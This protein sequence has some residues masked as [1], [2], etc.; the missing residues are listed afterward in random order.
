MTATATLP[1]ENMG[2]I[3]ALLDLPRGSVLNLD[4]ETVVLRR[5]DFIGFHSIPTHSDTIQGKAI[6]HA[7]FA[8]AG[9]AAISGST[10]SGRPAASATTVGFVFL[11]EEDAALANSSPSTF[12]RRFDPLTEEIGPAQVEE[13]VAANLCY[14]IAAGRLEQQ[15]AVSYQQFTSKTK[16]DTWNNLTKF[17]SQRLLRRRGIENGDKLVPGSYS[18]DDE[19]DPKAA[20]SIHKATTTAAIIDGTSIIYPPIPVLNQSLLTRHTKHAGTK[21]FL[22]EL[23]P[24][25]RTAFFIDTSPASLVLKHLLTIEYGNQFECLL[26]DLQLSYVLFLNLHCYTSFIHWRDLVAMLSAVDDEGMVDQ[27]ELYEF[28]FSVMVAQVASMEEEFFDD[29]VFSGDN[30]LV[31]ALRQLTATA[32]K[33]VA[34]S[35][36]IHSTFTVALSRLGNV[37]HD[38][39]PSHFA[40]DRDSGLLTDVPTKMV[41]D[42][43]CDDEESL[44]QEDGPV[45]VVSTEEVEASIARSVEMVRRQE[46]R[47]VDHAMDTSQFRDRYPMLVAA[48]DPNTEDLLMTCARALD[49]AVDVSLV[50]EAAAYLEEVEAMRT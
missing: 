23:A 37:L 21:L 24:T 36:K 27:I 6:F 42:E 41:M 35:I 40:G 25:T 28:L 22:K 3:L 38:K 18:N 8:R 14:E 31:P 15:R 49:E 46:K 47:N 19:A 2:G 48:M 11:W 44:H 12:V 7:V 29:D 43:I 5:D 17:V 33:V 9:A 30:F 39:F 50:R 20:N 1:T 10:D 4:G 16:A 45:I 34:K 26:G 13:A 32:S